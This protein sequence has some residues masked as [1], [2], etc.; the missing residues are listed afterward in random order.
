MTDDDKPASPSRPRA[1]TMDEYNAKQ[2]AKRAKTVRLREQRLAAE[3]KGGVKI[4]AKK[5]KAAPGKGKHRP[6]TSSTSVR[7]CRIVCRV[8]S[9]RNVE[10]TSS[11]RSFR[12]GMAS[13][14]IEF[15]AL[16]RNTNGQPASP[17]FGQ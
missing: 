6:C 4:K 12:S 3:A 13:L 2:E 10:P 16:L 1:T 7:R 11:Q 5:A 14:S 15:A 8:G 17:N 9:M